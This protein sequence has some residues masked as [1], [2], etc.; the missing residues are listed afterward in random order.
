M[1]KYYINVQSTALKYYKVLATTT[2]PIIIVRAKRGLSIR[3]N[4]VYV[5]SIEYGVK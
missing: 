3:K 4:T 5:W 1:P 2:P